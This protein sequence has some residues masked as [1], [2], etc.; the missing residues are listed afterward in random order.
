MQQ[1]EQ[2]RRDN[3]ELLAQVGVMLRQKQVS[4]VG[5]LRQRLNENEEEKVVFL[6]ELE[7]FKQKMRGL[8]EENGR[9]RQELNR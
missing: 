2:L 3:E 6:S 1:V 8:K 5:K 9:L 7:R 4:N